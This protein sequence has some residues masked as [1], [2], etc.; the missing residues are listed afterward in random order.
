[1]NAMTSKADGSIR[2]TGHSQ[3]GDSLLT[4]L[5]KVRDEHKPTPEEATALQELGLVFPDPRNP[6]GFLPRELDYMPEVMRGA[7]ADR[8]AEGL[9]MLTRIPLV[10][11]ELRQEWPQEGE[12][13]DLGIT[14]IAEQGRV[15]AVIAR[16]ADASEI[17]VKSANPTIRSRETLEKL[18]AH[19]RAYL[20]TGRMLRT[21]YSTAHR[22]VKPMQEWVT[23]ATQQG[24]EVR[25][26]PHFLK[27]K[28]ID[29][30]TRNGQA[31]I[32][33]FMPPE[34]EAGGALHIRHPDIVAW[35]NKLFDSW[36]ETAT[37]WDGSLRFTPGP[38]DSPGEHGPLKI[39]DELD[40]AIL[41]RLELDHT[42]RQIANLLD[43]SERLITSR[44]N[45]MRET[46]GMETR[47][48]LIAWWMLSRERVEYLATLNT[49]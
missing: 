15:T 35:L 16:A 34:G 14:Y 38:N 22:T 21:I 3:L 32:E 40:L 27:M 2:G 19:D 44:V 37:P 31:F 29:G 8:I 20:A 26:R 49:N 33:N 4:A 5:Q 42:Q 25:T 43:R 18:E 6:G 28:I 17:G 24:A 12:R 30:G 46:L 36:W 7:A 48:G 13:P 41:H 11:D 23:R 9:A 39:T 1:M 47:T 45:R 10:M